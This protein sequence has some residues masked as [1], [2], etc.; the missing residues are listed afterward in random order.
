[1]LICSV[2]NTRNRRQAWKCHQSKRCLRPEERIHSGPQVPPAT[3]GVP[4]PNRQEWPRKL[5]ASA[6][7]GGRHI[8][9]LELRYQQDEFDASRSLSAR[10]RVI[11]RGMDYDFGKSVDV[12]VGVEELETYLLG[13]TDVAGIITAWCRRFEMIETSEGQVP[14]AAGR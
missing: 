1:M 9:E 12:L 13:P 8:A 5:S 6:A 2:S 11:I 3:E 10:K 4:P 7:R 14:A